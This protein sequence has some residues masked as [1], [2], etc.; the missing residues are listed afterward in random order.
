MTESQSPPLQLEDAAIHRSQRRTGWVVILS[1]LFAALSVLALRPDARVIFLTLFVSA[2]VG[3]VG[4]LHGFESRPSWIGRG[5]VRVDT[6]GISLKNRLIVAHE[7]I[8]DAAVV[9][10][11]NGAARV[12]I[13]RKGLGQG[14]IEVVTQT[15]DQAR[16]VLRAVGFDP[17]RHASSFAV[18]GLSRAGF[19]RMAWLRLAVGGGAVALFL[20]IGNGFGQLG[21]LAAILP[22]LALVVAFGW[23]SRGR[24]TVGADGV[25]AQSRLGK[26]QFYKLADIERVAVVGRGATSFGLIPTYLHLHLRNGKTAQLLIGVSGSKHAAMNVASARAR[27]E[28]LAER[29]EE[30]IGAT[31]ESVPLEGISLLAR[32]ARKTRAWVD[33][34][35]A[36]VETARTFRREGGL[37]IADLFQ[38]VEDARADEEHRAAAAV[39]LAPHLDDEGRARVRIVAEATAL[40]KLRVALEASLARD[41]VELQAALEEL[42]SAKSTEKVDSA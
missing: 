30:A 11:D 4:W 31:H 26:R 1:S 15:R 20:A 7:E 38:V 33:D 13:E 35:R 32:S 42:A 8:R 21:P 28:R 3:L 17:K 36:L 24:V 25:L 18:R 6:R 19:E 37:A 5:V 10:L 12:E 14:P 29:I 2:T 23:A 39:A 34:L 9:P 40:P 22:A 27:A 41:D 16:E